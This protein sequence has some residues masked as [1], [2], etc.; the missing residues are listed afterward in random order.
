MLLKNIRHCI[1]NVLHFFPII[2]ENIYWCVLEIFLRFQKDYLLLG[3][4]MWYDAG[5]ELLLD[6][7]NYVV[8]LKQAIFCILF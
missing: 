3:C 6:I 1:V 7:Q 5:F 8:L 4:F 2:I